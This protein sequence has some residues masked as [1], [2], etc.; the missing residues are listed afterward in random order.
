[1]KTQDEQAAQ[2][3]EWEY[4]YCVTCNRI[5]YRFELEATEAGIRCLK[6]GGYELEAPAWIFCPHAMFLTATKCP[7]AGQGIKRGKD[8]IECNYRCSFRKL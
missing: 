5:R 8:G 7:R 4:C 1:M 3:A 6:C 2:I